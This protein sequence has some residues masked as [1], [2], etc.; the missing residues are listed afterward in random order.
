[1]VRYWY[2][3]L[4][5]KTATTTVPS[6][7]AQ[8]V[9]SSELVPCLVEMVKVWWERQTGPNDGWDVKFSQE[10]GIYIKPPPEPFRYFEPIKIPPEE[11]SNS[12]YIGWQRPRDCGIVDYYN[13]S[14]F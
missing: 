7:E 12:F 14:R 11:L 3:T 9:Y 10:E 13:Y 8:K 5:L 1:M 2:H 4:H 6:V